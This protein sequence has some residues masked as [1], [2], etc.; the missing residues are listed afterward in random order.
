[1]KIQMDIDYAAKLARLKLGPE[2]REQLSSQLGNILSHIQK[3]N[4][5]DTDLVRPTRH[6]LTVKNVTRPDEVKPSLN[7]SSFLKH[8]PEARDNLFIVPQIIE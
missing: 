6:I 2:E 7:P 4:E 1:M 5:L 3:L 8:A